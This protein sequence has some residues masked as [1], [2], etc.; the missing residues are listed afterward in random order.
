MIILLMALGI[1]LFLI[2]LPFI[3][4]FK[5][6]N[7]N[8]KGY[9]DISVNPYS[10]NSYQPQAVNHISN[11]YD[12]YLKQK[13]LMTGTEFLFYSQLKE[14]LSGTDY[15]IFSKVRVLDLVVVVNNRNYM[16]SFNKVCRKHIDFVICDSKAE[17]ICAL[18]LNDRSHNRKDRITRDAFIYRIFQDIGLRFYTYEPSK[19][20]NFDK[21]LYFLKIVSQNNPAASGAG[22]GNCDTY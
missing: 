11:N 21:D 2:S 7:R 22:A 16:S 20:Y 18:E 1:L 15:Q 3:I 19:I 12:N 5:I 9:K 14:Y 4:I 8:K 17:I 6:L 13:Y 10:S